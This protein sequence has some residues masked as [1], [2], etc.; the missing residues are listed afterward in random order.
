V[1]ALGAGEQ[2]DVTLAHPGS[3]LPATGVFA[4]G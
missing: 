1:S 4:R 3:F 2:G